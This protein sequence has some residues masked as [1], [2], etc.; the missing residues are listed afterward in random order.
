MATIKTPPPKIN[1]P[2]ATKIQRLKHHH[3]YHCNNHHQGT[4][5]KQQHQIK[6]KIQNQRSKKTHPQS[7]TIDIKT[8]PQP[9]TIETHES[10]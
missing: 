7:T 8:H 1:H 9:T 4:N 2:N 5:N 6:I 10:P 3:P